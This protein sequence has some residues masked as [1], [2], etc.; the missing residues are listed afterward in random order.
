MF[1]CLA[2][3]GSELLQAFSF[4]GT[5]HHNI[6]GDPRIRTRVALFTDGL[7]EAVRVNR[8]GRRLLRMINRLGLDDRVIYENHRK[9]TRC[10][11][12]DM[13]E[14]LSVDGPVH[15]R[16]PEQ[17]EIFDCDLETIHGSP[18]D[19]ERTARPGTGA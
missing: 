12:Y 13:L 8:A 17:G 16:L 14:G 6:R 19:T 3:E 4:Q 5:V 2:E 11:P 1:S 9:E 7:G 15:D 18:L 10:R